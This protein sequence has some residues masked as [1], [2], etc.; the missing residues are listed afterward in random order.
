MNE[1]HIGSYVY[2]VLLIIGRW[3]YRFIE[4]KLFYFYCVFP[5]LLIL[6][7]LYWPSHGNFSNLLAYAALMGGLTFSKSEEEGFAFTFFSLSMFFNDPVYK[8]MILTL[9]AHFFDFKNFNL[10]KLALWMITFL[11]HFQKSVPLEDLYLSFLVIFSFLMSLQF[12]DSNELNFP[13]ELVMFSSLFGGHIIGKE[14]QLILLGMLLILNGKRFWT[15]NNFGLGILLSFVGWKLCPLILFVLLCVDLIQL[16]LKV[17]AIENLIRISKLFLLL[18]SLVSLNLIE[19]T[20]VLI[21]LL[22]PSLIFLTRNHPTKAIS[23]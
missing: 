4:E 12:K 23:Q 17:E 1:F 20:Y 11:I 15:Q 6:S 18:F 3:K 19:P 21:G 5:I 22:L 8:I 10:L 2:A 16:R 13:V 7:W 14:F 9:G